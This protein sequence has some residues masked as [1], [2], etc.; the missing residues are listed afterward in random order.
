MLRNIMVLLLPA[1]TIGT[2]TVHESTGRLLSRHLEATLPQPVM[3]VRFG[4]AVSLSDKLLRCS[5]RK[6]AF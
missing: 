4:G 2:R 3:E 5:V 6:E 1:I